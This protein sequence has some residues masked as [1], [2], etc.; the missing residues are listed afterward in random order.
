MNNGGEQNTLLFYFLLMQFKLAKA[1]FALFVF[2]TVSN[3]SNKVYCF[4]GKTT[5]KK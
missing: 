2:I 1:N 4:P 3:S 5:L